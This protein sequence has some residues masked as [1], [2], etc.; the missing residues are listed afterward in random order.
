[1]HFL[2]VILQ[3]DLL[4]PRRSAVAFAFLVVIPAGNLLLL[5]PFLVHQ[6]GWP[7]C[8][9]WVPH[10]RDGFIVAKVGIVRSATV[11]SWYRP[12]AQSAE[13]ADNPVF[14]K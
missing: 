12:Y 11:F 5:L 8:E 13:V 6:D 7:T 10:L 4:W 9:I 2:F 1:L 14:G 3:G